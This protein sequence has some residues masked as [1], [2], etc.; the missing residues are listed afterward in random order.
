MYLPAIDEIGNG[1]DSALGSGD[2]IGYR[3]SSLRAAKTRPPESSADRAGRTVL[4]VDD[5]ADFRHALAEALRYEGHE[6]IEARSGEAALAVLDHVSNAKGGAPDLLVLDLLM[7]RMSGLEVIQRLRKSPRW[8]R[9]PVLV[10][11]AV[12]DPML[13]VRLD[14]PIVFKPDA[15]VVLETIRRRLAQDPR[16]VDWGK[17]RRSPAPA[18]PVHQ[19]AVGG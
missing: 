18:G 15:E 2:D 19:A 14:V 1:P 8:A 11:T 4:L 6:V 7:P 17:Q 12:N 3:M 9:L 16:G 10:V 5:D 13:P